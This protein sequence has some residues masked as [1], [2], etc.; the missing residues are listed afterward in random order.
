MTTVTERQAMEV[1][2]VDDDAFIRRPLELFLRDEGF[3]PHTADDGEACLAHVRRSRPAVII[4]DVMMPGRDGFATCAALKR[5][6]A[7][8]NIPVILL[9]GRGEAE[10]RERS[11]EVGAD[12]L[13][14]KP[15]SPAELIRTVRQLACLDA[16]CPEPA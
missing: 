2:I 5:D 11:R 6:P 10:D 15:Y 16:A 4:M 3:T 12:R 7:S 1:L 14:T 13:V 8:C 9:T